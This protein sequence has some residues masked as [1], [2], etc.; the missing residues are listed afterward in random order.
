MITFFSARCVRKIRDRTH[1]SKVVR[2]SKK[3]DRRW[4]RGERIGVED[5]EIG[6]KA[7]A[8]SLARASFFSPLG[9]MEKSK[10]R[11]GAARHDARVQSVGAR[12]FV[13]KSR[14]REGSHKLFADSPST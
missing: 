9:C 13:R 11:V 7:R 14:E 10:S 8:F 2:G 12:R 4:I 6:R 5:I 1:F 3:C